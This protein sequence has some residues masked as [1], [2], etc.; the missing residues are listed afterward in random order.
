M[1][2]VTLEDAADLVEEPIERDGDG[3]EIVRKSGTN[4]CRLEFRRSHIFD[5]RGVR[6]ELFAP[7][8]RRPRLTTSVFPMTRF[9][10]VMDW[11]SYLCRRSE[12][13]QTDGSLK[14]LGREYDRPVY[15][16]EA[17]RLP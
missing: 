12:A 9:R 7:G 4:G 1:E 11:F 14:R 16:W 13:I 2:A 6:I 17:D 10:Q 5:E 15:D 3:R 8:D